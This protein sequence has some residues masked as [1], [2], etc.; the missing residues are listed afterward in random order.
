MNPMLLSKVTFMSLRKDVFDMVTDV[1]KLT[2]IE[3][4]RMTEGLCISF[5][6]IC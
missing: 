2:N 1:S 5:F 6:L 3:I 4:E